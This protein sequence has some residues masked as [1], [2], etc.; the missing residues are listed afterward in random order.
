MGSGSQK[1][2]HMGSQVKQ[3]FPSSTLPPGFVLVEEEGE[4]LPPGFEVVSVK[5]AEEEEKKKRAAQEKAAKEA[6]RT[7]DLSKTTISAKVDSTG[8]KR[9]AFRRIPGMG[10]VTKLI[11][12]VVGDEDNQT[13]LSRMLQDWNE[14]NADPD[15]A[16]LANP[17]GAPK[18]QTPV[19]NFSIGDK[20]SDRGV[21]SAV[22][23]FASSLTTPENAII[24]AAAG[25]LP[26]AAS[27]AASLYF[28]SQMLGGG[29]GDE[30]ELTP[31]QKA[32][33]R[34]ATLQKS[35]VLEKANDPRLKY[36]TP[37]FN[38]ETPIDSDYLSKEE[39]EQA[40]P[41]EDITT[42]ENLTKVLEIAMGLTAGKHG[43]KNVAASVGK[44]LPVA[45]PI[46]RV[47]EQRT[48]TIPTIKQAPKPDVTKI[49]P[50]PKPS[51]GY[52]E[53]MWEAIMKRMD[54]EL[55]PG[56][57]SAQESAE[58]LSTQ[59]Y[60]YSKPTAKEAA[61]VFRKTFTS[62]PG[63]SGNKQTRR[64]QITPPETGLPS[65][66][67][68]PAALDQVTK[69]LFGEDTKYEKLPPKDRK[70]IKELVDEDPGV[71]FGSGL[72]AL[73]GI[74]DKRK[75][76]S[77]VT[78]E[79]LRK[80]DP[81]QFNDPKF[82]IE[83][84]LKSGDWTEQE[85]ALSLKKH[86]IGRFDARYEDI[87]SDIRRIKLEMNESTRPEE[88]KSGS[89]D[90]GTTLGSGLGALQP[91]FA[92]LFKPKPSASSPHTTPPDPYIE[93]LSRERREALAANE[94]IRKS[95]S[96][97]TFSKFKTSTV[98]AY[99][100]IE[101][102]FRY[103]V[104]TLPEQ[105]AVKLTGEGSITTA[106]DR[107]LKARNIAMM[108]F[109]DNFRR[110]VLDP[111]VRKY[112]RRGVDE[113]MELSTARELKAVEI[114]KAGEKVWNSKERKEQ[115]TQFDQIMGDKN[116]P[117]A[118]KNAALR[119]RESQIKRDGDA[120]WD[121]LLRG[122]AEPV[123]YHKKLKR[124]PFKDQGV[125]DK[126]TSKYIDATTAL[127]NYLDPLLD[128]AQSEFGLISDDMATHLK[129]MYPDYIP[130]E[131]IIPA[132][133]GVEQGSG[134]QRQ[135]GVASVSG[136]KAV[137]K[138]VRG[139]KNPVN[140]PFATI[141]KK[142]YVIFSQGLANQAA[143]SVTR[144]KDY[145][146][147]EH[148]VRKLSPDEARHA[149][150]SPQTHISYLENGTRKV[151]EVA[152]EIAKAAHTLSS[153]QMD[154]V[155][156]YLSLMA[157]AKR[158]GA[159]ALSPGFQVANIP[160]DILHTAVTADHLWHQVFSPVTWVQAIYQTARQGE[161]W[162]R[163]MRE[164]GG[165][166]E[167]AEYG[168]SPSATIANII[169]RAEH[170]KGFG[171]TVAHVATSPRAFVRLAGHALG[172]TED[173]GR[174]RMFLGRE[175]G[176]KK[177]GKSQADIQAEAAKSANWGMAP[178]HR[179]GSLLPSNSVFRSISMFPNANIQGKR[180]PLELLADPKTRARTLAR[181]ASTALL[182]V[183]IVAYWN[184]S[185]PKRRRVFADLDDHDRYDNLVL[186]GDGATQG[187]DGK[188]TNT[189]KM[190]LPPDWQWLGRFGTRLVEQLFRTDP[191]GSMLVAKALLSGETGE[192]EVKPHDFNKPELDDYTR[193]A[194][195]A[196][197]PFGDTKEQVIASLLPPPVLAPA[198][199]KFKKSFYTNRDWEAGL[200]HLAPVDRSRPW[201]T[202]TAKLL[203]ESGVSN[204]IGADSP[205]S[206]ENAL[207]SWLASLADTGLWASDKFL[208]ASGAIRPEEARGV[209][210]LDQMKSRFVGARGGRI[211]ADIRK[212]ENEQKLT[213][214]HLRMSGLSPKVRD[215]LDA[216]AISFGGLDPKPY[217]NTEPGGDYE[218][219]SRITGKLIN[220]A[221]TPVI[222]HPV[223]PKLEQ[224]DRKKFVRQAVD[225]AVEEFNKFFVIEARKEGDY[226]P[227]ELRYMQLPV[228]KRIKAM[229]LYLEMMENGTK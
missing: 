130:T 5:Q 35:G 83:S 19:I 124:T 17:A 8:K 36:A 125:I 16:V 226:T 3:T 185:D 53:A 13:L 11:D 28:A 55:K 136:Q 38:L 59:E 40:Q 148:L 109:D 18:T 10:G 180:V 218:T 182:P 169:N 64:A 77:T 151:F 133:E 50:A 116:S 225:E 114:A 123:W 72:G 112:G 73:Q 30:S 157:T 91:I 128:K 52:P 194:L 100:P 58:V 212:K 97:L 200:E 217:E 132:T 102:P 49:S 195:G 78:E 171:G 172:L 177:S 24:G 189:V 142:T 163:M 213:S 61:Q 147:T 140:D 31:E 27:G 134:F 105:E 215:V 196:V 229:N 221:L 176:L 121:K 62:P 186:V 174:M 25:V 197:S 103:L 57:K 146:D 96:K 111:L 9:E 6:K 48:L 98:D 167:L 7:K 191:E 20:P 71:I 203:A 80:A 193:A 22:K 160:V 68:L 94:R 183:T 211:E 220:K 159:T 204:L 153:T 144:L 110:P 184:L 107:A 137:R 154:A 126:Y 214:S 2:Q 168:V 85:L 209:G 143:K 66:V 178:Y 158:K 63:E 26:K 208:S 187:K 164:G 33:A 75:R 39:L 65:G 179:H 74:F 127:R 45:P 29:L 37:F 82:F 101:S 43:L 145:A 69:R 1:R 106:I 138:L 161:A 79:L 92:N 202:K 81:L 21:K 93:R 150:I 76:K 46:P 14:R 41:L 95:G 181:I 90:D 152:P 86:Y 139:T 222:S 122:E 192:V 228:E 12:M 155:M 120:H 15:L 115:R 119:G 84:R 99:T 47:R 32:L 118:L 223:F 199:T 89:G 113:F 224:A 188:W 206:T 87:L 210:P 156:Q 34:K 216:Y 51:P 60:P 135:S 175:K 108:H 219:R 42:E 67:R 227:N 4:G 88:G 201:T 56:Q 149:H 70:V 207:R 165:F 54:S 117:E 131:R 205:V 170:R 104:D 129:T 162:K 141:L 173:I 23:K 190:K 198:E 44:R 166:S